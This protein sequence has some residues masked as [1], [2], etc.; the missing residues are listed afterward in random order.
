MARVLCY[1]APGQRVEATGIQPFCASPD[2]FWICRNFSFP[3]LWG[4]IAPGIHGE[5]QGSPFS[6]GY[7]SHVC[8]VVCGVPVEYP[9]ARRAHAGARRLSGSRDYQSLGTEIQSTSLIDERCYTSPPPDDVECA[10]AQTPEY[11]LSEPVQ[12]STL[13]VGCSSGRLCLRL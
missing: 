12:Y 5:Q 1:S 11:I 7:Y 3:A 13:N 8:A 2:T 10:A 4:M 9:S 6:P